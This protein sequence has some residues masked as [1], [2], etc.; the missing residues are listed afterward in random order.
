MLE[1]SKPRE[2]KKEDI[3]INKLIDSDLIKYINKFTHKDIILESNIPSDFTI[4]ADINQMKQVFINL[5]TNSI[6][7]MEERGVIKIYTDED[8][9]SKMVFIEDNGIGISV[10]DISK[11]FDPFF[12]RRENGTGLGLF[13]T[14]NLMKENNGD[15]EFTRLESGTKVSLIFKKA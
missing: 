12:T 3:S 13:I 6:E 14:Y 1:Y 5:I 8:R 7:A 4:N 9:D 10:E 2:A 11:I 15:I